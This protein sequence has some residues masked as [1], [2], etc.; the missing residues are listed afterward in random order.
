M[1]QAD[2]TGGPGANFLL[3]W[4]GARTDLLDLPSLLSLYHDVRHPI[5]CS[6]RR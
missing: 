5:T 6:L 2:K 4:A 1:K 3:G